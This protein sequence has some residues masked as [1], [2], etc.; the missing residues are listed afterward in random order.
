MQIFFL[1]CLILANKGS[2]IVETWRVFQVVEGSTW[3]N[4]KFESVDTQYPL[5]ICKKWNKEGG[6]D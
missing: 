6:A 2:T 1:L 4:F 5:S 3:D